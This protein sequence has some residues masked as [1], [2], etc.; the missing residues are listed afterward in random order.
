V[1][2]QTGEFVM[3]PSFDSTFAGGET[4]LIA[5]TDDAIEEFETI[6]NNTKKL[7]FIIHKEEER[8]WIFRKLFPNVRS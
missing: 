2:Y 1:L 5:G 8:R 3:G 7:Y 6:I 4:L